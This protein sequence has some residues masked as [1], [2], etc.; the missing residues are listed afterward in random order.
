[1]QV[2][3]ARNVHEALPEAMWLMR[4][5]GIPQRTRN[6][7]VAVHPE[8]VTTVYERPKERVLFHEERDANPF[9]H[10]YEG[11]WMLGGRND[12]KSLT[13]FVKQM[14][15][16]S[17]DGETFAGAYGHRWRRHFGG[18]DQLKLIGTALRRNHDCRRQVLQVFDATTDL[19]R[20]ETK[21]DVPCN[22]AVHFQVRNASLDM[23]VFNRSNDI[24]WGTYGANAVHFSM[25][26]EFM[27][28]LVEVPVGRYWQVSDN[29]HAYMEPYEKLAGLADKAFQPYRVVQWTSPYAQGTV[30]PFNMI[31]GPV[32]VW[33]EDLD[34]F[35]NEENALGYRDPFF[36]RVALPMMQTHTTY[37]GGTNLEKPMRFGAAHAEAQR[38]EASDWQR[39][40]VEWIDRRQKRWEKARPSESSD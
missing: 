28:A 30:T 12:V 2:I 24:I 40:A 27:A 9:F 18:L 36:R 25:L 8:P 14:S 29:W 19:L 1:M 32:D 15:E 21:S 5:H 39:A 11:L 31:N 26:Q 7:L 10:F 20:Q 6:G 35:L 22:I 3:R 37:K 17:D 4:L 38:I 13:R 23:T 33:L 16:Y 34:M